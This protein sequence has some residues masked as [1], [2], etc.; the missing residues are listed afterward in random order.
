MY[1]CIYD[2]VYCNLQ[3]YIY[4]PNCTHRSIQ[5]VGGNLKLLRLTINTKRVCEISVSLLNKVSRVP[6][7]PSA[8]VP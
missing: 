8:R 2:E 7:C 5:Y 3:N 1:I 4:L 6:K